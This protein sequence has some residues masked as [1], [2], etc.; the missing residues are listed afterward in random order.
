MPLPPGVS[1]EEVV[2]ALTLW[3]A[4]RAALS[5]ELSQAVQLDVWKGARKA[6]VDQLAEVEARLLKW[7]LLREKGGD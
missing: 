7:G 5:W 4:L 1:E 2:D 3:A 6:S